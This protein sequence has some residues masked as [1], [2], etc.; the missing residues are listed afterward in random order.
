MTPPEKP[1]RIK[2]DPQAFKMLQQTLAVAQRVQ[3][4]LQVA[5]TAVLAANGISDRGS[6]ELEEPNILILTPAP[7]PEAKLS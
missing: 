4:E 1:R 5:L 6:V 2:I 3:A 7:A